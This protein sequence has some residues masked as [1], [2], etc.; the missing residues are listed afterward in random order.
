DPPRRI[1][2]FACEGFHRARQASPQPPAG[3]GG[4]G[5]FHFCNPRQKP[6]KCGA[7]PHGERDLRGATRRLTSTFGVITIPHPK[8]LWCGAACDVTGWEGRIS[9]SATSFWRRFSRRWLPLPPRFPLR[10][11][12]CSVPG[13]GDNILGLLV[14]WG[15][16]C[17]A[18]ERS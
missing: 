10:Y 7:H 11:G 16:T 13:C 14:P 1:P 4:G 6:G 3:G 18:A 2:G 12:P 5:F 15:T 9:S 17:S 8:M